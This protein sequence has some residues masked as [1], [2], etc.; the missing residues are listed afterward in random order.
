MFTSLCLILSSV[1]VCLEDVFAAV[2]TS[3]CV[4][5]AAGTA[6]EEMTVPSVENPQ[7]SKVKRVRM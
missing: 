1:Y 5:R 6:D 2:F 7:A 3:L 4:V